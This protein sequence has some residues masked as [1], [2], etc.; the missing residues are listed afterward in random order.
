MRSVSTFAD[1]DLIADL[2]I[3][4]HFERNGGNNGNNYCRHYRFSSGWRSS[5]EYG[6]G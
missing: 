6:K 5:Y 1:T 4:Q 3:M 2:K